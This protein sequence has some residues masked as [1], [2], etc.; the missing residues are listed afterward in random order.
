MTIRDSNILIKRTNLR[1]HICD[2]PRTSGS[3]L[4]K[5]PPNARFY[6][7]WKRNLQ[8]LILVSTQHPLTGLILRS[9]AAVA[10]EKKRHSRSPYRW[11]IHPCSMLRFYW[12]TIMTL[13]FLY[14]FVTVP[15]I[16]CFYRIGKSSGPEYW[17]I[18]YPFY[19][20]CII[21]IFFNFITG[22][23]SPD[24]Y[25]IFLDTT[26]I[27]RR[28]IKG[29]FFIDFV[30][31]IPYAWFYPTL[32]LPPGPNSN[33]ILLIIELLPI[34]KFIRIFTVRQNVQHINASFGISQAQH[35]TIWFIILTLLIFHWNS[36]ISYVFPYIVMHVQGKTLENLDAN[37]IPRKLHNM[38]DWEV[39]L[40]FV[41]IGISNFIGSNFIEF[42]NF[43]SLDT[44]IR[45]ILLL[46]GKGYIIYLIVTILQLLESSVKP[47]L[48]YQRIIHEVKE[49]IHQKKL[50]LYLQ[51]K[52]IFYYKYRYYDYFFK[53][54]TISNIL[55]GHLNQEILFHSSQRLLDIMVLR[56]LPRNVLGDLINSLKPEI[57]LKGDVIYKASTEGEYMYFIAS[58]T[59]ALITFSG[60]EIYHLHDG[61]HFGEAGLIY[62]NQRREESVIAL[63]ICELLRLHRRDFKRFFVANSE[64]YNNLEY[65]VHERSERIKK[66]EE[67]NISET[68]KQ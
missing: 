6:N 65:I 64:F 58:G 50:P 29:Y 12:D 60:K 19:A 30:S 23:V 63:E 14:I 22:F 44:I 48:K 31:S 3:N 13:T 15:H 47:K 62:P 56:N 32:I 67:Q 54:N 5:L 28:Y 53:E 11:M 16:I 45:C 24:G 21:D 42:K 38:S 68:T 35:I 61:D 27:A 7:R 37:Y 8:K 39:Y 36:C 51:N 57:Y 2:L 33:S 10:F 40:M 46:L 34:L 9:Q 55:S 59:V 17:N 18:V 4:P 26:L 43:G 52:L 49:Y 1:A 66:L 20:V 25:E 41:H